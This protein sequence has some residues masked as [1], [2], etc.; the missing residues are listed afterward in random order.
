MEPRAAPTHEELLAHAGWVRRLA[1]T[2]V[3]RAAALA[4]PAQ[5]VWFRYDRTTGMR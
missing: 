1:R 5:E 2:L 3:E 4:T